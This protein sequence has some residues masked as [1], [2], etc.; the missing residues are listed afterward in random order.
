AGLARTAGARTLDELSGL[1]R[2]APFQSG[3]MAVLALSLVGVPPTVGFLGKFYIA[4]GAV[5]AGIWPVAAVILLSTVLTLAYAAR[6]LE[7]LYFTPRSA[8]P[9]AG[10]DAAAGVAADGGTDA[11]DDDTEASHGDSDAGV[12]AVEQDVAD[13]PGASLGLKVA[14]VAAALLAVALGFAGAEFA[15][16]L[17]PFVTEVVR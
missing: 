12:D 14:L 2:E 5:E 17:N 10:V 9:S 6:F 13:A 7:R 11:A 3:A 8:A 4:L 16:A 15:D 1:G